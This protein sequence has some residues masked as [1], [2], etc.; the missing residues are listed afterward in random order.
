MMNR[1][2]GILLKNITLMDNVDEYCFFGIEDELEKF[3]RILS[4]DEYEILKYR[5]GLDDDVFKSL[6]EVDNIYKIG[7]KKLQNIET[8]IFR[9]LRL[10]FRMN[11]NSF[12][13]NSDL[14]IDNACE[15]LEVQRFYDKFYETSIGDKES[16][17]TKY[18]KKVIEVAESCK[19]KNK[20]V[21]K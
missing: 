12:V 20:K 15:L 3:F 10:L 9:K 16:V 1:N 21:L 14:I 7:V 2:Y 17:T 18:Y 6:E 8:M 13:Y 5:Y 19:K 4:D 11:D